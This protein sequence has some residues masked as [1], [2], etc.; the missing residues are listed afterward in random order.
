M[1]AVV[2]NVAIRESLTIQRRQLRGGNIIATVVLLCWQCQDAMGDHCRYKAVLLTSLQHRQ[3]IHHV[4]PC[5]GRLPS[6]GEAAA[7]WWT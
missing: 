2:T 7:M 1:S 6:G 4:S 5:T 3:H